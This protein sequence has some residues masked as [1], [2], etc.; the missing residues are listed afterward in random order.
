MAAL[1]PIQHTLILKLTQ[2]KQ[3]LANLQPQITKNILPVY[4]NHWVK[5][6]LANKNLSKCVLPL[7]KQ[8]SCRDL[9]KAELETIN[10]N[11]LTSR[12]MSI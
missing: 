1:N 6:K 2:L 5:T 11:K 3:G 10:F 12:K 4:L 8:A 7:R 9:I